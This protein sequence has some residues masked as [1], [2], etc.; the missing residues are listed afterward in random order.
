LI[1]IG[2]TGTDTSVGKTVVSAAL[3]ALLR[4][5]GRSVAAMKPIES[6]V[7]DGDGQGDAVLLRDAAGNADPLEVVRPIALAARLAPWLAAERAGTPIDLSVLDFAFGRLI[8]GRDAVVVE[9]SGGLLVP[10]TRDVGFDGLFV[11]WELDVVVAAANRTGVINHVLLTVRAAHDAGLRV[12]G[13]VLTPTASAAPATPDDSNLAALRELLMPVPVI[14][15][16][17]VEDSRDFD[18]LARTAQECGM[19]AIVSDRVAPA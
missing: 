3:I 12:R 8:E 6:G 13:V 1:R 5:Q 4:K 7:A 14:I 2:V 19:E 9:G 15:F 18:L 11:S 16:P 10:I 17:W